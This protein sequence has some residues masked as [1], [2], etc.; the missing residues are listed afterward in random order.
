MLIYSTV[1]YLQADFDEIV[2]TVGVWLSHKI[3]MPMRQLDLYADE[4][5]HYEDS[6][7]LTGIRWLTDQARYQSIAYAHPDSDASGRQWKTEISLV[8]DAPDADIK[9]VLVLSVSDISTLVGQSLQPTRPILVKQLLDT[10][11]PSPHTPGITLGVL[12]EAQAQ[13]YLDNLVMDAGRTHPI[14]L[15]SPT[16]DGDYPVDLDNL[17]FYMGGIAD[18]I[19]VDEY[20]NTYAIEE[21]VGRNYAAWRG[22]VNL[23]YPPIQTDYGLRVPNRLFLLEDIQMIESALD[24]RIT[25]ENE[26]LKFITHRL[27]LPNS[28]EL[29]SIL[30]VRDLKR[31]FQL[32]ALRE[33]AERT[34]EATDELVTFLTD[35][36]EAG[37]RTNQSLRSD[38]RVLQRD[39]SEAQADVDALEVK[40]RDLEKVNQNLQM[41]LHHDKAKS[42]SGDMLE[43]HRGALVAAFN[44]Q[45]TVAQALEIIEMLFPDRVIVL[46][47]ARS[48]AQTSEEFKYAERAF[49]MLLDL[50]TTYYESLLDQNGD[51]VAKKTFGKSYA[52]SEGETA[53]KNRRSRRLRTFTYKG[54]PI[55]M[56]KHL[57]IGVKDSRADTLRVHFHWDSADEVIVIG[58]CGPHLDQK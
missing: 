50:V 2:E 52:A 32:R 12:D 47:T 29:M 27:N 13:H 17:M 55:E 49:R 53:E 39:L 44:Q 36:A 20:A 8:Q 26:L 34:G 4:M 31:Q 19:R 45:L 35:Y 58:H 57:K 16:L 24:E 43:Q 56:F 22:A 46:E 37:D 41:S 33:E 48:S 5:D 25:L 7:Q 3:R 42:S 9:V 1:L 18:V 21:V 11:D 38:N 15:V 51:T 14:V 40:I 28:R 30:Q 10:C 23:I 6:H 54:Q